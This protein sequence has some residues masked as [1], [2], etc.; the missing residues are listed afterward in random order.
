MRLSARSRRSAAAFYVT[1]LGAIVGTLC[2]TRACTAW[3]RDGAP[4]ITLGIVG[5]A[6]LLLATLAV[7]RDG[8]APRPGSAGRRGAAHARS[9]AP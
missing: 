6:A 5:L 7:L 3:V 1:A 4:E 2:M 8:H 9:P